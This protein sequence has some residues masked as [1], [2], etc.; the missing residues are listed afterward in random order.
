MRFLHTLFLMLI[1]GLLSGCNFGASSSA[2]TATPRPTVAL[3]PN[4]TPTEIKPI[5]SQATAAPVLDAPV[6]GYNDIK[7]G[8][9]TTPG[10]PDE[11]VINARAGE[12]VNIVLNSQF[13]SYVELF[14]P[15]G[16]FI[17]GNDDNGNTLDAALFELQMKQSGPHTLKVHGFD[18]ATGPYALAVT[19]GHPTTGGGTL[20]DGTSRT[21]MLSTQGLKWKYQGKEGTYLTAVIRA[22]DLVDA[23]L[24]LYDPDGALLTTDDDSA[25]NLNPEIFEFPLPADGAYTLQAQTSANTGIVSLNINSST[26]TS[27]GGPL[28]IGLPQAGVLKRGRSHEWTFSGE[29]GQIISL[30]MNSIDFDAFLELRNAEGAILVENDDV[31]G[32]SNSAIEL[33]TLPATDTYT[34]VARGVSNTD[35]GNYE[36]TLKGVK[37]PP[38]GGPL[39][40][41]TDTQALLVPGQTNEWVFE[42]TANTFITANVQSDTLDT[43]L[44]LY[45]PDG[46]LLTTD[47]DS[48]GDLNAAL[49]NFPLPQSGQYQLVVKSA[50]EGRADGGVYNILLTLTEDLDASGILTSGRPVTSNLAQGEQHT[51]TF[52]A[53]EGNRVTISM[54]SDTL[55]TYLALYDASGELIDLNDDYQDT[56]AVI[57]NVTIPQNG[58]YRIVAR[59]YS[60]QDDGGEYTIL[61]EISD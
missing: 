23:Q 29:V 51:W 21:V 5:E 19:G 30:T 33:F 55:D 24:A 44:E 18:G 46:S 39:L 15:D 43:F 27:G 17:A 4:P 54:E 7:E 20:T 41:D 48:G 50:R 22:E 26:R 36:I 12:R 14:N 57:A 34:I 10:V 11:W 37:V 35:G 9:L 3:R 8:E 16:E 59:T 45:G 49:L 32:G 13:D 58:E 2:S 31:H 6:M 40:V 53:E 60:A 61:L 38:G 47:D 52:E 28:E 42:G 1:L 56:N 25:G